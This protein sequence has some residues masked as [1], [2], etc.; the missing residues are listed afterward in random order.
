MAHPR[1]AAML[2]AYV[3]GTGAVA[4][5]IAAGQ[6]P[7]VNYAVKISAT[8]FTG[9][10]TVVY[11]NT[12]TGFGTLYSQIPNDLWSYS[13]PNLGAEV[14][15]TSLSYTPGANPTL[16]ARV[17]VS[18]TLGVPATTAYSPQATVWI[19]SS[20]CA[21]SLSPGLSNY[22]SAG[23]RIWPFS[24][25][26]STCSDFAPQPGPNGTLV[27]NTT[28]VVS[29]AW[30]PTG[31]IA[32]TYPGL[33]TGAITINLSATYI[34]S[35]P[36]V[37]HIEV[38]Q[39]VQDKNNGVDLIQNKR[40]VARVFLTTGAAPA[41][42][43]PTQPLAGL[44]GTLSATEFPIDLLTPSNAGSAIAMP[45]GQV[46]ENNP[47]HSLNFPLPST[48]TAKLGLT[49]NA[50]IPWAGARKTATQ[51]VSLTQKRNW[52]SP[53]QIGYLMVCT[54][55]GCPDPSGVDRTAD[56][57]RAMLPVP[58]VG[59][60]QY[61]PVPIPFG[62]VTLAT[63]A[64]IAAFSQMLQEAYLFSQSAGHQWVAWLPQSPAYL[65]WNDYGQSVGPIRPVWWGTLACASGDAVC[66][67]DAGNRLVQGVANNLG[68]PYR[69]GAA[70][71]GI[72]GYDPVAN[73]MVP[74]TNP[75][76]MSYS[77][78]AASLKVW[79]G[80][81]DYSSLLAMQGFAAPAP[82]DPAASPDSLLVT[83][84]ISADGSTVTP[85]VAYRL[86]GNPAVIASD[87]NGSVCLQ[88]LPA[89]SVATS[90]YCF[91]PPAVAGADQIP[92]VVKAPLPAGA[93]GAS[94]LNASW[95]AAS[96]PPLVT[97]TAPQA[98]DQWGPTGVVS[99][100]GSDPDGGQLTYT[101]LYSPDGGKTWY[102]LLMDSTATSY[103]VDTTQI[104]GGQQ[105][106]FRL[107]ATSGFSTTSAD[108]GPIGISQSPA[109]SLSSTSLDFGNLTVGQV[110]DRTLQV[111]NPGSGPLSVT[112]QLSGGLGYSALSPSLQLTV[113]PGGQRALNLRFA[114]IA[115][116]SQLGAMQMITNAASDPSSATIPLTGA[117]F[118]TPVP[119]L[120]AAPASLDFGTVVAGTIKDLQVT[121]ANN[122]TATLNLASA[123][124]SP[125][126]AFSVMSPTVAVAISPGASSAV[127][128]RFA[129]KT[130]G[131]VSDTVGINSDDP[132]KPR[133]AILVSGTGLVSTVVAPQIS[134]LPTSLDFGT[135][136]VG[137]TKDLTFAVQNSGNAPLIVSKLAST[138]AQFTIVD[139]AGGFTVAP[140][141]SQI[142]R[143]RFQPAAGG[144]QTGA[145]TIASN[146]PSTPTLSVL[147]KGSGDASAGTNPLPSITMLT[148]D[149]IPAVQAAGFTLTITGSGFVSTSVVKWN[150]SP[151]PTT[152]VSSTV[153][154]AAIPLA[155]LA[156]PGT[157]TVTVETPAPG[158][159]ASAAV[160]FNVANP[161]PVLILSQLDASSCSTIQMTASAIDGSG[162]AIGGL[163]GA[164]LS[165]SEDGAPALCNVESSSDVNGLSVALVLDS[166][167]ALAGNWD[168]V[169][170]AAESLINSLND[171]DRAGV[172]LA[173]TTASIYVGLNDTKSTVTGALDRLV[174]GGPTSA[175]YDAM[176]IATQMLAA[177]K[178]RRQAI[179]VISSTPNGSGSITD[180]NAALATA[181]AAGIPVF[182]LTPQTPAALGAFL[183]QAAL[184]TGG[185]TYQNVSSPSL[186]VTQLARV[187]ANQY[188]LTYSP[189]A[190]GK[191]HTAAVTLKSIFG[192][193]TATKM[194]PRCGQ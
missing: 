78:S 183:R 178:G 18:G 17:T 24:L 62:P 96:A 148:P 66:L 30:Q 69:G 53:L 155:D 151:R 45:A 23:V 140:S 44:T 75:T 145:V 7:A 184:D 85:G 72:T 83:G 157:A 153:I 55:T 174:A 94:L 173:D 142:V 164:N 123:K 118:A 112:A 101:L 179:V 32:F 172:A 60:V 26:Q 97:V 79:P 47:N 146:D 63:P 137:A 161:S 180:A 190:S 187:L 131:L 156:A 19:G 8:D 117:A 9:N 95:T 165:C 6:A 99:W 52:P 134:A 103:T 107:L 84:M 57:L 36:L 92:F 11:T 139:P 168:T 1:S 189:G 160:T 3:I 106:M 43:P 175:L 152:L 192:T 49:L 31:D 81:Q 10:Q 46:D 144:P 29:A 109:L 182:S 38:V 141:T 154:Q 14:K 50:T 105:V 177:Q 100:F 122:G 67:A 91:T 129:P 68:V 89:G 162:N 41:G 135:L 124:A 133:I 64:D 82:P 158:G 16:P 21:A 166:T 114:P 108:V 113:P 171:G 167:S 87:P 136:T 15:L 59:G 127:T 138:N 74:S 86:A 77:A 159:G 170:A 120:S 149:S 188:T 2:A 185:L 132:T 37:D 150:G 22:P 56:A 65:S 98:G 25:S 33:V 163:S 35:P 48:W 115:T 193:T 54:A 73:Q 34:V 119:S 125:N 126:S 147:V 110:V 13:D 128:V 42:S 70:T 88:F 143:V 40:A 58:D 90:G 191:P 121:V 80:K 111:K 181:R 186:T 27:V 176:N 61:D 71:L 102:P 169:R 12:A 28:I 39:V 93:T 51:L 4:S 104:A 130:N 20:N 194:Y 5:A 116:G 76:L